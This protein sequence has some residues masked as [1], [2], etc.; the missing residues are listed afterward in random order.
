MKYALISVDFQN[1]YLLKDQEFY[2]SRPG[3]L[4]GIVR[5]LYPLLRKYDIQVHQIMSDYR[6]PS[7]EHKVGCQPG[8]IGFLSGLNNA[9]CT[10][11]P[12]YKANISPLW[13]RKNIG[14]A[15]MP[16]EE[17]YL[18]ASKF[19]EWVRNNFG[20]PSDIKIILMTFVKVFK[21]EGISQENN[22]TMEEFKGSIEK[23]TVTEE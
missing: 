18:N 2:C 4:S 8:T 21:R 3:L 1:S 15:D 5:N 17:P 7:K 9:Y 23:V 14:Q 19:Y 22:A 10:N 11:E 6:A 16:T 12:F 20:S 13:Q